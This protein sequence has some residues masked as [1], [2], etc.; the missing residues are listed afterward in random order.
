[1]KKLNWKRT[2]SGKLRT[3]LCDGSNVMIEKSD[4]RFL[5]DMTLPTGQHRRG[6]C[7]TEELA[8][9]AYV[10]AHSAFIHECWER[11]SVDS[12]GRFVCPFSSGPI[13]TT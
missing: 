1:M 3:S 8:K 12:K 4:N 11:G 2:N 7:D 13:Y 6:E 9:T 10:D 5:W